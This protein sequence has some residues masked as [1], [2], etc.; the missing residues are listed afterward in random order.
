MMRLVLKSF[1]NVIDVKKIYAHYSQIYFQDNKITNRKNP[2]GFCILFVLN[3]LVPLAILFKFV[4][5]L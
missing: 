4:N 2:T 5:A 3:W 1:F